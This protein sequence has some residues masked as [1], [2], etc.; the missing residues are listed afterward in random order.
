MSAPTT[1][2]DERLV[3][4][5]TEA[6]VN[7]ARPRRHSWVPLLFLAP[8]LLG[9]LIFTLV[10]L[11][12]GVL[13]AFTDW[14]VVS[15]LPGLRWV[16]LENFSE[17][18]GDA[19]F[20]RALG[21]TGFYIAVSVPA[22][23]LL[24][25]ALANVLNKPLPGRA[26]LRAIFFLPYVVNPIA[27]GTVWLI[28]LNPDSGL[29][30][31]VLRVVGLENGPG[32]LTSS[33]WALPALMVIQVWAGVGYVAVIYLAAYQDL[34]VDLYD[35][36]KVDGAGSWRRFQA[37][38]WPALFPT[39]VFL[40]ITSMIST[41]QGFGLIAFLTQGGPGEA[42]TTASFAMYQNGFLYYRFGYAAAIG[43]AMFALVL[44]LTAVS[45]R[46]QRGRGMNA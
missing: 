42:T 23:V 25:L 41:S 35:A 33:S 34:P 6:A 39:T 1:A 40:V 30:N 10:P 9:V 11:V 37:I 44:T 3:P 19:A 27:V 12:A 20:G 17:L 13:V 24:G 5:S 46:V 22:T 18:L 15:G 36:A 45:W 7:P 29:V 26:A 32:W 38:T 31:K 2:R 16:G 4:S 43:M 28:M 8:N 14:D 21:R